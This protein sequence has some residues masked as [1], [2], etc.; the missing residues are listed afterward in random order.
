MLGVH[1]ASYLGNYSVYSGG[2]TMYEFLGWLTVYA[3]W[4]IRGDNDPKPANI[5]P[6]GDKSFA[7]LS[8][9]F[10]VVGWGFLGWLLWSLI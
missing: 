6:M 5:P 3:L 10:N 1:W 7:I 4:K 8:F 2:L 9:I